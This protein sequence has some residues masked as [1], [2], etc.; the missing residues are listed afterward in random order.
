MIGARKS[1]PIEI[2]AME[3]IRK[4]LYANYPHVKKLLLET[5]Y[6]DDSSLAD[7]EIIKC[8]YEKLN[9]QNYIGD[10]FEILA[11]FTD[12]YQLDKPELCLEKGNFARTFI[13]PYMETVQ[14]NGHLENLIHTESAP[15]QI[16]RILGEYRFPVVNLTRKDMME[17]AREQEWM[18]IMKLTWFCHKP[19]LNRYACGACNPCMYVRDDGMGWRIPFPQRILGGI[20]K[21]AYNSKIVIRLR[22]MWK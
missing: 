2:E 5:N 19:I 16:Y 18:Q 4:H 15:E 20:A 6:V 1:T 8:S 14:V 17:S 12:Q 22:N 9:A 7:N 10:Q 11:R 3:R 13:L 21:K